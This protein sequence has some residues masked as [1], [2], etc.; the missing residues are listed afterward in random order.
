VTSARE[1]AVESIGIKQQYGVKML[2][3][4]EKSATIK[5]TSLSNSKNP[6]GRA[7]AKSALFQVEAQKRKL[8]QP[9][10][11]IF[12]LGRGVA[13]QRG[14]NRLHLEGKTSQITPPPFTQALDRLDFESEPSISRRQGTT[15]KSNFDDG[16][17]S[18]RER[19]V[20]SIGI[21][22]PYGGIFQY[23]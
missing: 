22:Q 10:S 7:K 5:S 13:T 2:A 6:T 9:Y 14:Q 11:D 21:R 18:T 15:K 12:Q 16:V 23:P 4:V 1:R 8:K 19:A 3:V 20:E 17:T